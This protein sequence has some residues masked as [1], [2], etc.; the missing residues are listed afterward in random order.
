MF[1]GTLYIENF[2]IT[3]SPQPVLSAGKIIHLPVAALDVFFFFVCFVFFFS[4]W[5]FTY[6][7]SAMI[8]SHRNRFTRWL[9]AIRRN[10]YAGNVGWRHKEQYQ[11]KWTWLSL[12][13][14]ERTTYYRWRFSIFSPFQ[15]ANSPTT[16]KNEQQMLIT[17][18][19][20]IIIIILLIK[21]LLR[22]QR[23][24]ISHT[25]NIARTLKVMSWG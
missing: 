25:L 11:W 19:I 8:V 6:R 24:V 20:I 12:S 1:L 2:K 22:M 23:A 15:C 18:I 13:L 14:D 7:Q 4:L 10:A 17:I 3:V 9:S 16:E 21:I 5:F